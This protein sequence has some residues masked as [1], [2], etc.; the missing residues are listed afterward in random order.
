M[1]S[2]QIPALHLADTSLDRS[3]WY[4]GF[5]LTFL[6]T[7]EDTGGAF[8]LTYTE[9]QK[10]VS[11]EPPLHVHTREEE[12]FYVMEGAITAYVGDEVIRVEAGNLLTL[13]RGVP[14]RYTIGTEHARY[15]NL[16]TPGGFEGFL[17]ELSEP[18]PSMTMPPAPEGPPDIPRLIAAAAKYG[19][20]IVAPAPVGQ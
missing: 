5:L 15:L 3:V 14:H 7:S 1:T 4:G 9:A 8:S 6:A 10:G 13:P 16:C 2:L 18:A 12:S 19:I 20:A 17:R 11:V